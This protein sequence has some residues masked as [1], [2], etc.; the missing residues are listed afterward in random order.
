M[1]FILANMPGET[2][3][4]GQ[5]FISNSVVDSVATSPNTTN[6]KRSSLSSACSSLSPTEI[7]VK[8][9][10]RPIGR[11]VSHCDYEPST[12]H[13][14]H[15]G[16]AVKPYH[17]VTNS[18]NQIW[19]DGPPTPP[20][21]D[22]SPNT[23][24][25]KLL[26][27]LTAG[28]VIIQGEQVSHMKRVIKQT[29]TEVHTPLRE[30]KP[31]NDEQNDDNDCKI[32]HVEEGD[33]P[34]GEMLAKQIN[35]GNKM[36]YVDGR[37]NQTESAKKM[38]VEAEK[39]KQINEW[40]KKGILIPVYGEE[41]EKKKRCLH[42]ERL[43]SQKL[44]NDKSKL[45]TKSINS[46]KQMVMTA[47]KRLRIMLENAKRSGKNGGKAPRGMFGSKGS[48]GLKVKVKPTG[49][50]HQTV[51]GKT[52]R[53][54]IP[55]KAT[56]KAKPITGGVK[57]P[58]RYKPGTVA[59][60]EIRHFQ[61]STELLIAMLPSQRLVHEIAQDLSKPYYVFDLQFQSTAM[62]ALQEA[63]EAYLVW[64]FDDTN[65][66]AIHTKWQTIMPKDMSLVRRM[67]R[68]Y[69]PIWP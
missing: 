1:N 3:I 27:S 21:G 64:F 22:V 24:A 23:I 38:Y 63:V 28:Q 6:S 11:N 9:H 29:V 20:S 32:V 19:V 30:P 67:C 2:P 40:V 35:Y 10:W 41:D 60:C 51:G 12:P 5:E 4:Q 56:H 46:S 49:K 25:I 36:K 59:L 44:L 55:T 58:H 62:F 15:S 37:V 39:K 14:S 65:L 54:Q 68:G 16:V 31:I 7:I 42:A 48:K 66:C 45:S 18:P 50:P 61:K 57:K 34:I 47:A 69:D 53:N 52:P 13:P 26:Q 33:E 17:S 8:S 43:A